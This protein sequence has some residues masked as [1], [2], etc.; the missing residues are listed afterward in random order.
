MAFLVRH[1]PYQNRQERE[2]KVEDGDPILT[3]AEW[4]PEFHRFHVE[5]V[6]STPDLD[7]GWLREERPEL[8][9]AIKRIEDTTDDLGNA[10]LSDVLSF[11]RSWRDLILQAE[12]ERQ[13]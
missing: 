5:V 4:Y 6:R 11:M 9:S 13:G 2:F 10:R 1:W 12:S 7:W 3:P 8:H